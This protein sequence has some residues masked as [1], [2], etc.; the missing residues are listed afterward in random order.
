LKPC[1]G[2]GFTSAPPAAE[3]EFHCLTAVG[4]GW[5]PGDRP[6]S[7]WRVRYMELG[8]SVVRALARRHGGDAL[9][10]GLSGVS[11]SLFACHSASRSQHGPSRAS[12]GGV[13]WRPLPVEH[14]RPPRCSSSNNLST[15]VGSRF[16]STW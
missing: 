7:R 1:R 9:S 14:L 3:R 16:C 5:G 12:W 11:D 10:R 13:P 2:G 4:F 8:C 15:P 6:S